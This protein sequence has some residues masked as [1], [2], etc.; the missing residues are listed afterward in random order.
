MSACS[1]PGFETAL[2]FQLTRTKKPLLQ[3]A[4][5]LYCWTEALFRTDLLLFAVFAFAP[6]GGYWGHLQVSVDCG[7][8]THSNLG[9]NINFT[10]PFSNDDP[11]TLIPVLAM[12]INASG[13]RLE[14]SLTCLRLRE[15]SFDVPT[16]EGQK[17]ER[18]H[19]D[20]DFSSSSEFFVTIAV[21]SFLY[22]LL[23]TIVHIFFQNAYHENNHG[24]LVDFMVTVVF[25]F[26]WLVSSSAWA[27]GLSDVKVA[28]DPDT[29]VQ[30]MS[31]CK[32]QTAKCGSVYG[33]VWSSLNSSVVF[34]YLNFVLWAGNVWFVFKETGWHKGGAV[35]YPTLAPEKQATGFKQRTY[36]QG[37]FDQPAG[38]FSRTGD[39]SQSEY[40]QVGNYTS[41][42][43][44]SY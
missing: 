7:N 37:S 10:Y 31:A 36:N 8:E 24:P 23:A 14:P 25:S 42:G 26:M 16:R 9:I 40:S 3:A 33:P 30:L 17:Q 41:V 21:F 28:T 18:L 39:L 13:R 43:P 11:L 20:G 32:V 27:K 12:V 5:V 2:E 19:L 29:V 4:P 44:N 15:V 6:C 38:G 35:R 22:S 1:P 34:G